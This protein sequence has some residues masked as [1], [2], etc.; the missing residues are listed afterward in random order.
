M[1]SVF[2]IAWYTL[3]RYMVDVQLTDEG[4]FEK[5]YP[6]GKVCVCKCCGKAFVRTAD[7][8][9]R[10]YYGESDCERKRARERT[11]RKRNKDK[12]T[13]QQQLAKEKKGS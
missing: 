3:A 12:I 6:D 4:T 8:N 2:D 13:E 7:Q 10:Q 9:H 1:H 11:Q 5:Q